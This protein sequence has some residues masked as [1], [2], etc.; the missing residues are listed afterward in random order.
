MASQITPLP[1]PP[2]RT[3]PATFSERMDAFLAA[4]A[5]FVT[6]TNTV[7]TEAETD[8]ATA[9]AQAVVASTQATIATAQAVLAAASAAAAASTANYK[10]AWSSQTGAATVPYCVSHLGRYW[11]LVSNLANVAAKT[12]GTDPEWMETGDSLTRDAENSTETIVYPAL[13]TDAD[14]SDA[15]TKK[16]SQN[17]DTGTTATSFKINSSGNEA[18]IQTTGLTGDRDYTLPDGDTMLAGAV[19]MTHNT[20]E[21]IAYP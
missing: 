2:A 14:L 3:A 18:D 15:V 20:F 9:T 13:P 12:P 21:I 19:L 17:S 1:T 4:L 6:Q 5:A 10:G 7:A 11:Q 8:S 16:H